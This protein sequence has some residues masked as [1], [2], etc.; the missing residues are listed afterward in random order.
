MTRSLLSSLLQAESENL[1]IT[2]NETIPILLVAGVVSTAL[3]GAFIV[4]AAV[5][6]F[7]TKKG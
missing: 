5:S 2:M 1:T 7:P 3:I 4:F 6:I